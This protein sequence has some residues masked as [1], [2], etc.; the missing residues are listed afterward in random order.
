[1]I[2]TTAFALTVLASCNEDQE[3]NS[4][5][6][7]YDLEFAIDKSVLIDYNIQPYTRQIGDSVPEDAQN[8]GLNF[9]LWSKD[10]RNTVMSNYWDYEGNG[11]PDTLKIASIDPGEY[12]TLYLLM[13]KR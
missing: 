10:K 11:Y 1:M 7:K 12:K 4:G 8:R 2:L 6:P 5:S 13:I 3:L 9:Y